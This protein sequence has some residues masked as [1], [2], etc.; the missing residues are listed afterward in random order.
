MNIVL[1][2]AGNVA[3]YLGPFLK[4]KGHKIIQLYSR[5][6][7]N[8]EPLAKKLKCN[9]T[10]NTSKI[11]P[12]ADIYIIALRDEAIS[13]FLSDIKFIPRLIVHTSG[14]V[15]LNVFPDNMKN[16][17]V[18]YPIQ[19][20]SKSSK[21]DPEIIPYCIEGSNKK[22]L[23]VIRKLTNSLSSLVYKL[24]SKE[25][26]QIHLTAVFVNNFTNYLFVLANK[27]L[28]K[29]KISFDILKPLI[30]E[31]AQKVMF[32]EPKKMQT[33]P[34]VR[35]D[36]AV[37]ENHLKILND[38]PEMKDIYKLLSKSIEKEYGPIL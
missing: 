18:I 2:G 20:F 23:L 13:S 22:S 21:K 9:H 3:S 29:N 10:T 11:L 12:D 7:K 37:I 35:G 31:T 4:K 17:G 34:A 8:G 30:L 26:A 32:N 16:K 27:I 24:N 38:F 14:S 1:I 25:R 5:S 19:T 36:A 6:K 28:L 33:G 15:G